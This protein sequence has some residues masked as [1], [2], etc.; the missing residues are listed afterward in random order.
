MYAVVRS[1]RA[2]DSQQIRHLLVRSCA[3][4]VERRQTVRLSG[5]YPGKEGPSRTVHGIRD[6]QLRGKKS[7]GL[8][9]RHAG[10]LPF[11]QDSRAREINNCR[12]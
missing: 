1:W 2:V 11:Q 3:H 8:E 5:A 12:F 6:L 9:W 7:E 4:S 10:R